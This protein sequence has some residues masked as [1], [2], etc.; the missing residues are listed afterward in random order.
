MKC[1]FA[2]KCKNI[3][4]VMI[5]VCCWQDIHH[6]SP[7]CL[8]V[9]D[10]AS[11]KHLKWS[12]KSSQY[13]S[14]RAVWVLPFYAFCS[15][16]HQRRTIMV[17]W[18]SQSRDGIELLWIKHYVSRLCLPCFAIRC[19]QTTLSGTDSQHCNPGKANSLS[20]WL[21]GFCGWTLVRSWL[22]ICIRNN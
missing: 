19:V 3:N 16:L 10:F 12:V 22:Y 8:L 4:L 6:Q 2:N 1:C 20:Y 7:K 21:I 9:F 18:L 11:E 13:R 17:K 15:A 14:W 5:H